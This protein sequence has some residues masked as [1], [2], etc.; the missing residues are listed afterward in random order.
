MVFGTRM[1]SVEKNQN[2]LRCKSADSG[3]SVALTKTFKKRII[4]SLNGG[5]NCVNIIVISYSLF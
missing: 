2:N 3:V 1:K 4:R 5:L